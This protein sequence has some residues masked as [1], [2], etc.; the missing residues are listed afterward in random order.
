MGWWTLMSSVVTFMRT[1]P[2]RFQLYVYLNILPSLGTKYIIF[3]GIFFPGIGNV[4]FFGI[5]DWHRK[6]TAKSLLLTEGSANLLEN[7]EHQQM[8]GANS[9]QRKA[10]DF[11]RVKNAAE[12]G[13][14]NWMVLSG[15]CT[16][17]CTGEIWI[18]K[19]PSD[20]LNTTGT[21]YHSPPSMIVTWWFPHTLRTLRQEI[22]KK[23]KPLGYF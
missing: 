13:T 18:V 12:V 17:G 7:I 8:L 2:R 1:T 22:C 5:V 20:R 9:P 23:H 14:W 3:L 19:W 16:G 4:D 21:S 6:A 15:W 11:F 10:V